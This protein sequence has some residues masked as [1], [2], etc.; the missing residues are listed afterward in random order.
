MR[1]SSFQHEKLRRKN[2]QTLRMKRKT[3]ALKEEADGGET[4]KSALVLLS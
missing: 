3:A 1:L 4:E 2:V